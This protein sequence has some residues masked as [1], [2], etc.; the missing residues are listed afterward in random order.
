MSGLAFQA[1]GLRWNL[2][3]DFA[4][5]LPHLDIPAQKTT[6]LLGP[7][8]SGKSSLLQL[9]GRVEGAYFPQRGGSRLAGRLIFHSTQGPVDLLALSERQLLRRQLR[10]RELGLV[11]QREGLFSELSIL[12]NVSWPLEVQGILPAE[13]LG[14]SEAVLRRVGLGLDRDVATLSGGERKRLA[15]ARTLV[16][17]PRVLLLDE[18]FTGLDPQG[19]EQLRE[20]VSAVI[21]EEACTV[22]LVTHQAEDIAH[23]GDHFIL[24]NE[25][26]VALAGDR[27]THPGVLEDFIRGK[28]VGEL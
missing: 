2:S 16:W 10:G 22:V 15:L 23:F 3:R 18:C 27:A 11:F 24:L 6:L 4:L 13:A 26:E 1:E 28:P 7:S 12:R 8:G 25:G 21:D 9:L 19:V 20:L 17:E 14:R 5:S